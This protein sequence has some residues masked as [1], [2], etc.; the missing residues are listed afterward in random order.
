MVI[1]GADFFLTNARTTADAVVQT[2]AVR[3]E[4]PRSL[5]QREDSLNQ[6]QRAAQQ[7]HVDIGTIKTIEGAAETAAAGDVDAR[8]GLTPGDAEIGVFLVILQQHVEVRLM[9]L[10][11]VG[12]KCEGFGLA[13]G[14]DEFDLTD[15]TCHQADARR[16]VLATAEVTAHPAAQCL[17]LADVKDAVLAVPHQIATGFGRN[18]LQPPLKPL[19]LSQQRRVQSGFPHGWISLRSSSRCWPS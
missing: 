12:F 9:V 3:M 4:R 15:L 7:A 1:L 5:P 19:R 18:L 10:D 17:G 2:G 13:V 8:V 11:Q 14:D 16:Q 6:K